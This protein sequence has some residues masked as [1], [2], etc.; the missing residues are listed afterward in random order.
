[1]S[2]AAERHSQQITAW[3]GP[4]R[5]Q[6]AASEARMERAL[7]PVTEA[8]LAA[9]GARPG[10]VVLDIGCGCGGSSFAFA[11]A[12]GATGQVIGADVSAPMLDVARAGAVATTNFCWPTPPRMIFCQPR[13]I[14]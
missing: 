13:S 2:D 9:A 12:V 3:N 14:L 6:W 11:A 4:M 10:E 8:L 7:R 1:M 5:V